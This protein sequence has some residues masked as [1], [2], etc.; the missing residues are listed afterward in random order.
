MKYFTFYNY[1]LLV[2]A[3][4]FVIAI[5]SG[6]APPSVNQDWLYK[7]VQENK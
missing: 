7:T 5:M 6:C 4:A 1:V 2:A 3:V